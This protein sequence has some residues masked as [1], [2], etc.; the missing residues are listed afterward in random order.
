MARSTRAA[1]QRPP[2]YES[3]EQVREE[4][5]GELRSTLNRELPPDFSI[6]VAHALGNYLWY[7][8]ER[9]PR[10]RSARHALVPVVKAA[11]RLQVLI[12]RALP[13]LTSTEFSDAMYSEQ[14]IAH[15]LTQLSETIET[16]TQEIRTRYVA[17]DAPRQRGG[18][19]HEA[20]WILRNEVFMALED[21]DVPLK[22]TGPAGRVLAA[23]MTLVDRIEGL[24][25]RGRYEAVKADEW[26]AWLDHYDEDR[27]RR[28]SIAGGS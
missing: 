25:V 26:K 1:V 18:D 12:R 3:W 24:P 5:F 8:F 6:V 21:M 11:E 13:E 20:R 28:L 23:V 4:L 16:L 2:I 7:R 22:R 27:G 19:R 17:R 14:E 9:L 15:N 10:K